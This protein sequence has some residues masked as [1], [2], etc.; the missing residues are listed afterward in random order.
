MTYFYRNQEKLSDHG[1]ENSTKILLMAK[2][3]RL[4]EANP[5]I[6]DKLQFPTLQMSRLETLVK[7]SLCWQIQ[8]CNTKGS[9]HKLPNNLLYE[10]PYSEYVSNG[11]WEE[12]KKY[13]SQFA[14]AEDNPESFS[15][16]FEIRR[17]NYYDA[18]DKGDRKMMLDIFKR[19][20][21][22]FTLSQADLY[23]GL[24]P[25]FQLNSFR[26]IL[27]LD[28]SDYGDSLSARILLM[29]KLKQLTQANPLIGDKL[30]FPT[31]QKSRLETLVK[32]RYTKDFLSSSF[33]S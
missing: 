17:Q 5:L 20:L 33:A 32:L 30:Q 21:E 22:V 19:E 31:L 7:Q 16:F 23:R 1:D 26:C 29:A 10:D 11:D 4:I 12:V 13:L 3:K 24:V 14:N 15:I 27:Q 6:G 28:A 25:F 9:N 18:H 8:Q 2:L